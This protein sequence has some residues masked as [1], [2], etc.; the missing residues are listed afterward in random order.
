MNEY[1]RDIVKKYLVVS[2]KGPLILTANKKKA[3][4]IK[5][6]AEKKNIEAKTREVFLDKPI[7]ERLATNLFKRKINFGKDIQQYRNKIVNEYLHY[8]S[9]ES[10]V[11]ELAWK[12]VAKK[13]ELNLS[14]DEFNNWFLDQIE[15]N[16]MEFSWT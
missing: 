15:Y 1:V 16:N 2:E 10:A 4:E 8:M 5:E 12:K 14:L 9:D 6:I 11:E 7:M 3:L 13:Y